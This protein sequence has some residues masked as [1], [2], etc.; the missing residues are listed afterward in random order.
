MGQGN[1]AIGLGIIDGQLISAV[2]RDY[3]LQEKE[4]ENGELVFTALGEYAIGPVIGHPADSWQFVSVKDSMAYGMGVPE[5]ENPY[6]WAT[7][8][9]LRTSAQN[10]A[11]LNGHMDLLDAALFGEKRLTSIDTKLV[12]ADEV[13]LRFLLQS[14]NVPVDDWPETQIHDLYN[15]TRSNSPERP[16]GEIEN[17]SLHVVDGLLWLSTAQT[18]LNVYHQSNDGD[19]YRLKETWK[20][21]FD[22][23]G[24]VLDTKESKLNSSMGETGHLIGDAPERAWVTA[25]RCLREELGITDDEVIARIVSSGSLLRQKPA[26]HHQFGPIATEDRTHYFDVKLN[27]DHVQER[28]VNDEYDA[29][30]N[31]RASILLEWVKYQKLPATLED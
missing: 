29:D 7:A 25:R 31:L 9:E 22:P 24:N 21:I 15:Y 10:G 12:I 20:T 17:M 5:S 27:T 23:Q 8:E 4:R 28:Y 3:E 18:M 2:R 13:E 14:H 11:F 30:G 19:I 26:G 6:R 16:E 1:E